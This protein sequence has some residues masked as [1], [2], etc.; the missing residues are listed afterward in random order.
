VDA[1]PEAIGILQPGALEK[2]ARLRVRTRRLAVLT[3]GRQFGCAMKSVTKDLAV[4]EERNGE[5]P[6]SY[7]CFV[8][9]LNDR[10]QN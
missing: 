3:F 4:A 6:V 2:F 1:A 5:T 10:G 7:G 8:K 9:L